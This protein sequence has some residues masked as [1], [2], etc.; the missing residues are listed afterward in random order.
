MHEII[1]DDHHYKDTLAQIFKAISASFTAV[2]GQTEEEFAA[3]LAEQ[4][5]AN[6]TAA[7]KK[8]A[9]VAAAAGGAGGTTDEADDSTAGTGPSASASKGAPSTGAAGGVGA[10]LVRAGPG[11]LE[12]FD[13]FAESFTSNSSFAED[14]REQFKDGNLNLEEFAK[15]RGV[16]WSVLI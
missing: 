1:A 3:L 2:V 13:V 12:T 6:A 7:A 8:V 10:A 14:V 16:G 4:E 9:A 11:Y 15:V 5:S